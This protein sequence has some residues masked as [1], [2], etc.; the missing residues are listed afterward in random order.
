M[1]SFKTPLLLFTF[2]LAVFLPVSHS[3]AQ[4]SKRCILKGQLHNRS[5]PT[6]TISKGTEQLFNSSG[7]LIPVGA[8]TIFLSF[9][10]NKTVIM[11][12]F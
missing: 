4:S 12:K 5:D 11:I 2:L 6:L 10:P 7:A 3:V 8:D 1:L 9:F